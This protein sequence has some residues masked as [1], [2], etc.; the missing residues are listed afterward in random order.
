MADLIFEH[1]RLAA[2]YDAFDA[3]RWDL[4]VYVSIAEELRA[5]RVLDV[6]CGT[7][8]FAL[9]LAARGLEVIGADPAKASLYVARGKP[10]ADHIRWID[11]RCN[12]IVHTGCRWSDTTIGAPVFHPHGIRAL[13]LLTQLHGVPYQDSHQLQSWRAG[14][15]VRRMSGSE[16]GVRKRTDR[17]VSTAPR[18]DPTGHATAPPAAVSGGTDASRPRGRSSDVDGSRAYEVEPLAWQ[19]QTGLPPVS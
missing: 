8:T 17:E 14:C 3:N 12:C 19:T 18:S 13:P 5:R 16:G 6:G 10:G 1:P 7:G 9:M 15:V 11:G 2:I 4:E